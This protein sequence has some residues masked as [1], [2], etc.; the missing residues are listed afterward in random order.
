[1]TLPAAEATLVADFV[2]LIVASNLVPG[3]DARLPITAH[4][5]SAKRSAPAPASRSQDRLTGES[6]LSIFPSLP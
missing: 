1:M 6:C 3:L 5:R 2:E 4:A